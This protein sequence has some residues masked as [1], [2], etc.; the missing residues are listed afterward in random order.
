MSECI[1]LDNIKRLLLDN[2]YKEYDEEE[3]FKIILQVNTNNFYY[4]Y[5]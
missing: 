5:L 1:N 3:R 4:I 2:E